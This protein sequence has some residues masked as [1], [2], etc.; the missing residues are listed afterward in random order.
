MHCNFSRSPLVFCSFRCRQFNIQKSYILPTQCV[1]VCVGVGGLNLRTNSD[2]FP[3]T[4][5][6]LVVFEKLQKASIIFMY[7]RLYA[8]KNSFLTGRIAMK[9][10]IWG[11]FENLSGKFTFS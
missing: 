6:F 2:Y 5:Q 4:Y 8:R 3:L 9:F 7:V 1:Y 11:D 10:G